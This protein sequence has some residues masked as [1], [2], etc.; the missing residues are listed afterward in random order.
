[1]MSAV[2]VPQHLAAITALSHEYGTPEYVRGG[3]GN[4]SVKDEST[5][6]VKPSGATMAGLSPEAFVALHR[7]KLAELSRVTA[8]S[9][10]DAREAL[11]RRVMT[12][13]LLPGSVGRAS[14]EAPLHNAL[15]ARFVVHTHPALVNGMTCAVGGRQAAQTLFPDAQWL[16]YVDPGYTLCVRVSDKIRSYRQRYGMEPSLI[17][18]ANHGMF[19]AGQTPDELR[20]HHRRVV[21]TL[22]RVYQ[23]AGCDITA[24]IAAETVA[25][26]A[27][28]QIRRA[29]RDETITARASARFAVAAGPISPDHVVYA[30]AHPLRGAP[31]PEAVAAYQQEHG[32]FP[33]VIV[34]GPKVYGVGTTDRGAAWALE[35]AQDAALVGRLAGVF[36]GIQYMSQ[37][38]LAF[39]ESWEA[40]SYRRGQVKDDGNG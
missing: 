25:P 4:S 23:Q 8:P 3:G 13:A 20:E 30:R 15:E 35:L 34:W 32:C 24:D 1:M 5:L 38:A 29:Y 37:Q 9:E 10:P 31:T 11:V 12:A 18:L 33:S 2:T 28:Q 27:L 39:I 6:W 26:E 17:L 19:V 21:A 36:G 40:E 7:A 14:V 16:D 22:N